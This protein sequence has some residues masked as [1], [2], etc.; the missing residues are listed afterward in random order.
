MEK[1][2]VRVVFLFLLFLTVSGIVMASGEPPATGP[3]FPPSLE[4]YGD[5]DMGS[6]IG[7][8]ANRVRQ[9]PFNLIASLIFL[10]AI[11]HTFLTGRFMVIAHRWTHD[12]EEK[13]KKGLAPR[14]SVHHGAEIFHFLGEVEAVFGI[15]AAAL[16]AAIVLFFDWP[17]AKSYI[18]YKV[19]F[20]EPMFVVVIMTLAATRPILQVTERFMWKIANLMGGTLTAW[21]W[22]ILTVGPI[23]GSF[24]TE[25]AA[26]TIAAMLLADKFYSLSP[27][28]KFK[29]AT[30][31]LLFVNISVGGTLTSYAAPPVLMVA[32]P[33][34]WDTLFMLTHFGWKAVL[35]ILAAN[36]CYFLIFR[37]ELKA[38]QKTFAMNS[39]KDE[40]QQRYLKRADV[41]NMM[42]QCIEKLDDRLH[43]VDTFSE[44]LK[45]TGR[46]ITQRLE[47][48]ALADLKDKGVDPDLARRAFE[49][50]NKEIQLR[51]MR[52]AMPGLLPPEERPPFLDPD[53]DHRDDPVPL[54]VTLMHI[55]FMG[56]TII[57]AHYPPFF[58]PGLLFF[59]GFAQVSSPYQNRLNLKPALLV[60]FFLGGLVIHGGLQGWWIEPVLGN[61]NEIPLMLG[62]TIL[63]AFN[64]NAAITFLS[65]LVPNF[66]EGMKYAVVA[67]AVAGGG[68]TIIANAPNPAGLSILKSFFDEEVSPV[69]ILAAAALPTAILWLIFLVL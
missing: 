55:A 48:R 34:K 56:W 41:E 62:A 2:H 46:E 23:L 49:E 32:A 29:Y 26:M 61:L 58:I 47:K 19:N 36:L 63:T 64:D 57:N 5:T 50:R 9:E 37:S 4:S 3:V 53:W 17:T 33:W 30:L 18:L 44:Q 51:R 28:N 16:L 40:I 15:W 69:S 67:G 11:I 14:D 20:T 22:S 1:M 68:L 8:L 25:P 10:C 39:L 43:F 45:E 52:R 31:G 12:H 6:I 66:S 54:W 21:W 65:T 27:S 59:L 35:G 7:I 60:G 42:D 13:I 38:L 24:I